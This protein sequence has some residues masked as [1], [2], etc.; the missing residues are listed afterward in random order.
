MV[1]SISIPGDLLHCD[2]GDFV[3][4]HLRHNECDEAVL[5]LKTHFEV[6][7]ALGA[8]ESDGFDPAPGG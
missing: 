8:D 3:H 6:A 4:A 5:F 7:P 2:Y 1:R